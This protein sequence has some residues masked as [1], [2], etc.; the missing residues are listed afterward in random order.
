MDL[1]SAFVRRAAESAYGVHGQRFQD[2]PAYLRAGEAPEESPEGLLVVHAGVPEGQHKGTGDPGDTAGQEPDG[3]EGRVVGP[4]DVLHDNHRWLSPEDAEDL[5]QRVIE[6]VESEHG[7]QLGM[8]VGHVAERSEA[9]RCQEVVTATEIDGH[10][11][12]QP[13][14]EAADEG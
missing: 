4:V 12:A 8:L 9:A 2:D 13:V 1:S 6:L 3:I 14:Q 7:E 11:R 10:V 5:P